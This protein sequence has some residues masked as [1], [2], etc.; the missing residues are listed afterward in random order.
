MKDAMVEKDV[1]EGDKLEYEKIGHAFT[2]LVKSIEGEKVISIEAGFGRGKTF[3]RKAWSQHLKNENE[4]VVE[5]DV[6]QSDHSGDPVITLLGALVDALPREDKDKGQRAL[7]SAKKLGSLGAKTL[8]RAMLKSGADELFNALSEGAIDKL[9]EFDALDGVIKSVGNEMSKVAGQLIASQM[10]AE[11]V[12]K[13]ELPQQLEALRAA[14][15]EGAKHDRVIVI[16]DELD[17]CHPEYAISFLEATKLIFNQSGF[18]FC[19]MVNAEYLE[20][21]ARHRFGVADGDERYLDKFVDIRLKLDTNEDELLKAARDLA[22]NLP[23]SVPYGDREE[24]SLESAS[25]LAGTLAMATNPS[26]R[27]LKRIMLKVEVAMRCYADQPLDP[28]LLIYLAFQ[29]HYPV[30]V[31]DTFLPR[32][33]LTPS[34]GAEVVDNRPKSRSTPSAKRDEDARR[35][36]IIYDKAPELLELPRDRYR[37]PDD[38]DYKDWAK[39]FVYLAHVYIPSHRKILDGVATVIAD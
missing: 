2:N 1:W 23:L 8:T 9:E 31:T 20:R 18:I 17:R 22:R 26:M 27:K 3:F 13:V 32:A 21:L 14:L 19:L 4:V 10:A 7:E 33:F 36:E 29:D 6:Q 5:I 25:Q 38:K 28:S 39:A 12:R 11:K 34:A 15:V 24:F 37:F 30:E 16:I 35:N